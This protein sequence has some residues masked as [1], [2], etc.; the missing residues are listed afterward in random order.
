LFFHA[1]R[2]AFINPFGALTVGGLPTE[3]TLEIWMVDPLGSSGDACLIPAMMKAF[4]SDARSAEQSALCG[5]VMPC[6]N[7]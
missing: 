1:L 7:V 4:A 3:W 6:A 5:G 2:P